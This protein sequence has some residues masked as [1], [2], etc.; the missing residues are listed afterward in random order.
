MQHD[1]LREM[2][3][4][5][6]RILRELAAQIRDLAHRL[7]AG[8]QGVEEELRSLLGVFSDQASVHITFE[9]EALLPILPT[10][11]AWGP[12][13]EAMMLDHH[14]E[15]H[16]TLFEALDAATGPS[17]SEE[18]IRSAEH[19]IDAFL[20]HMDEEERTLVNK[21]VL[22]NTCVTIEFGG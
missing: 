4:D 6:H 1:T 20:A 15:E 11:D 5:Q 18:L 8:E 19:A 21:K 12:Q 2:L 10:L 22:S 9:N 16:L 13:R 14:M 17:S 3:L 7:R